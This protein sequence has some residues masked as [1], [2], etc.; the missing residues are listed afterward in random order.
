MAS[1]PNSPKVAIVHDWLYGGGAE[2]VVEQLHTLYP[3]SP[4]YT[5]YCTDEWRKRLDNKVVTGYLQNWPF[6]RLRKFLPLLRQWWFARLDLSDYDLIISSTG[7]GEAKFARGKKH[8][9]YCH[10]PPHFYWRKY[11]SYLR[12]P[13]FGAF[14]WLARIGLKLFVKPLR[15]RDYNA[16]QQVD[17][18]IANS[19]HIQASTCWAAL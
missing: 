10:S 7:N 17:A 9:C 4:I 11:E 12:N 6:S 19:T 18:F 3:D 1:A 5:S 14:D 2:K 13:G 8:I 16:A 15:K